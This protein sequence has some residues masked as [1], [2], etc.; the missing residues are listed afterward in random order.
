MYLKWVSNKKHTVFTHA[1]IKYCI[2]VYIF[3][4]W[5]NIG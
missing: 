1:G 3:D 4:N 2:E 5:F